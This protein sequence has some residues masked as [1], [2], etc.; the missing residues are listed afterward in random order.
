MEPG[1][2]RSILSGACYLH[3]KD[4]P[5]RLWRRRF[6]RYIDPKESGIALYGKGKIDGNGN[7]LGL[8]R[9]EE[10]RLQPAAGDR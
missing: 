2:Q 5:N 1:T 4:E 9:W 7:S 6:R 10:S 3:R 8:V